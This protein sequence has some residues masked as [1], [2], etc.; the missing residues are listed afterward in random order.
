MPEITEVIAMITIAA[1]ASIEYL[2]CVRLSSECLS[3]FHSFNLH[4]T[5]SMCYYSP[6]FADEE[7]KAQRGLINEQKEQV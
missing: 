6:H 5:V 1:I 2:L 4:N 7:M 3:P